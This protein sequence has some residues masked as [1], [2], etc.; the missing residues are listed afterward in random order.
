[1]IFSLQVSI[2]VRIVSTFSDSDYQLVYITEDNLESCLNNYETVR[3]LASSGYID[4]RADS[5]YRKVIDQKKRQEDNVTIE[6]EQGL[7]VGKEN[8]QL[9]GSD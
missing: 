2:L 7:R 3:F 9:S 6:L 8:L 5:T 4:F 1:M